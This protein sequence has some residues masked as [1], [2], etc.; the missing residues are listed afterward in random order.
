MGLM[1]VVGGLATATLSLIAYV[2][3]AL[4]RLEASLPDH[5]AA[6]EPT[7]GG[8]GAIGRPRRAISW[9]FSPRPVVKDYGVRRIY[10]PLPLS[11]GSVAIVVAS[12]VVFKAQEISAER[13]RVAAEAKA[14]TIAGPP[15]PSIGGVAEVPYPVHPLET[16]AFQG[17]RFSRAYGYVSCQDILE[18]QGRGPGAITVCQF[19]SPTVLQVETPRGRAIWLTGMRRASVSVAGGVP[20]CVLNA[21]PGLG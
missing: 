5:G 1:L 8:V 3:P 13:H 7:P 6:P 20:R 14:W 4:R 11:A 16:F 2:L 18:R 19:N 15:C 17:V 12:M 9:I 21:H 10:R